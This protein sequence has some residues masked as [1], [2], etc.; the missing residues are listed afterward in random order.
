[1]RH[2]SIRHC[3]FARW[4]FGNICARGWRMTCALARRP[5]AIGNRRT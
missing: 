4:I 2:F 3:L 5:M 1:M